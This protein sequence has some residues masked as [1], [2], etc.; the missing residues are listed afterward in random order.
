M[1]WTESP[2]ERDPGQNNTAE[3]SAKQQESELKH[4][5]KQRHSYWPLWGTWGLLQQPELPAS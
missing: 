1:L 3:W 2:K 4:Q 5:Q